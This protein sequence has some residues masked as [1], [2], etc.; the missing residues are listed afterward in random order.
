M[1]SAEHTITISTRHRNRCDVVFPWGFFGIVPKKAL[2]LPFVALLATEI[3]LLNDRKV[4][5]SI[6]MMKSIEVLF[7]SLVVYCVIKA[8]M[9]EAD[10]RQGK[11]NMHCKK[12]YR[13]KI[14]T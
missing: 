14:V 1:K 7:L 12:K 2:L 11:T 8:A 13:K 4:K 10:L 5:V 9:G 3:I 6:F